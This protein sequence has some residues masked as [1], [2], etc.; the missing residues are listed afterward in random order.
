MLYDKLV[1]EEAIL[2]T[3]LAKMIKIKI[4]TEVTRE[5]DTTHISFVGF[6]GKNAKKKILF[7]EC[8][9]L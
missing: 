3:L 4:C 9:N 1:E 5:A 7:V 6:K 2:W 8:H